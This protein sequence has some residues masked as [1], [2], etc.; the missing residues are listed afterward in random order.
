M[1]TVEGNFYDNPRLSDEARTALIASGERARVAY[2]GGTS[3]SDPER[4]VDYMLWWMRDG[5]PQST[6]HFA[7]REPDFYYDV[8]MHEDIVLYAEAAFSEDTKSFCALRRA[9]EEQAEAANVPSG[10]LDWGDWDEEELPHID[11]AQELVD[12]VLTNTLRTDEELFEH[13]MTVTEAAEELTHFRREWAEDVTIS[14]DITPEDYAEAYNEY[15][16]EYLAENGDYGCMTDEELANAIATD[17]TWD[18]R[19]VEELCERAGMYD[20]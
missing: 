10:A 16:L 2:E 11:T 12:A 5:H 7:D 4:A 9:I 19:A 15:R 14:I 3:I 8:Q 6:A 20:E 17:D 13:A 1:Y 18:E